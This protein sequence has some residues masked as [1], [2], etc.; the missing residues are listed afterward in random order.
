MENYFIKISAKQKSEVRLF[1]ATAD[2]LNGTNSE[3]TDKLLLN[4]YIFIQFLSTRPWSVRVKI[5]FIHL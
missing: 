4:G 1:V 2:S 5:F 3:N